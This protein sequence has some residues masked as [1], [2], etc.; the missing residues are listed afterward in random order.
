MGFLLPVLL[1]GLAQPSEQPTVVSAQHEQTQANVSSDGIL[2]RKF[3]FNG[4][5]KAKLG[6]PFDRI[7]IHHD[8]PNPRRTGCLT[9]RSYYFERRDGRA[10][11]FVGMTTCTPVRNFT[12]KKIDRPARLVPAN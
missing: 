6:S 3:V 12:T 4:A 7:D 1:L 5:E 11:E 9:M 8:L 2:A 10:P